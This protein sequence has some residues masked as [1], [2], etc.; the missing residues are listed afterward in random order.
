MRVMDQRLK[1]I[2]TVLFAI[3]VGA[4]IIFFAWRG[5]SVEYKEDPSSVES[6]AWKD[7]LS[8]VSQADFLKTLNSSR[9]EDA[10]NT[11]TTTLDAVSREL[12]INYTTAQRLNM[13]TTTLSDI[14]AK[15]IA[16]TAVDK[17][18]L[19]KARQFTVKDLNISRDNSPAAIETYSK[20]LGSITQAFAKA[21]IK[22]DIEVVFAVPKEGVDARRTSLIA[23]QS[24]HYDKFIKGVLSVKI[25]S[26]LAG[27]HLHLLQKYANIQVTIFPMAEIF[28]DSLKGLAAL[29]EYRKEV[30]GLPSITEEY[31]TAFLKIQ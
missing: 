13:S 1:K 30:A 3:L 26:L 21:Q 23:E 22:T 7:S 31:N 25:P 10:V 15:A 27:P 19:P 5:G 4:S 17:I 6:N 14:E 9:G 18:V 24:S 16:Q 11:A 12:F 20:A 8:V 2:F 28:T 29:A